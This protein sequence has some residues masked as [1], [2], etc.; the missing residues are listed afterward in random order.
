MSSSSSMSILF[1]FLSA[2]ILSGCHTQVT[3][4]VEYL[5]P[6]CMSACGG[7]EYVR[8]QFCIDTLRSDGRSRSSSETKEFIAVTVDLLTTNATSTKAK[9]DGLLHG[10]KAGAITPSLQSC[11][12]LYE[13]ILQRQPAAAAS[14]K[15]G[16]LAEA[17]VSLEKSAAAA[18][19]CE[20]LFGKSH[21]TSPLT[22]EDNNAFL[23]AKLGVAL[24]R[25]LN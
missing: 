20:G 8:V 15:E 5:V 22:A 24:I 9:I 7:D 23:L 11:Q 12:A 3:A 19:E 14:V 25:H 4:G 6:I 18:N 21:V 2:A 13:G 10:S 1:L 17:S 16:R